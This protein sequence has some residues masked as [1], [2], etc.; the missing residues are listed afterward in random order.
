MLVTVGTLVSGLAV[1]AVA[2]EAPWPRWPLVPPRS[3]CLRI[4]FEGL[5]RLRVARDCGISAGKCTS[6]ATL[7][8]NFLSPRI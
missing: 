8:L 1:A 4:P 3:G 2:F 5:G 7:N 6:N